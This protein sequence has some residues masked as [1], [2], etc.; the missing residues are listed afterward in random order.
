MFWIQYAPI[1]ANTHDNQITIVKGTDKLT[2]L[3][4]ENNEILEHHKVEG[5]EYFI[6]R[7]NDEDIRIERHGNKVHHIDLETNQVVRIVEPT[8]EYETE[9]E[10]SEVISP[11]MNDTGGAGG[12]YKHIRTRKM[13]MDVRFSI[14]LI[15]LEIRCDIAV[16][17]FAL[18]FKI[19]G[20]ILM[21]PITA[22]M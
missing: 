3:K 20:S 1:S 15:F 4:L 5:N 18:I 12:G 9:I 11:Y 21:H 16:L 13:S 7:T 2:I 17:F 8:I 6:A 19:P 14:Q 10:D 22:C